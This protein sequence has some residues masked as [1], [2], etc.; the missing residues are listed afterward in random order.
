MTIDGCALGNPCH[1]FFHFAAR[2][3]QGRE[4][5]TDPFALTMIALEPGANR[6]V[7]AFTR[8]AAPD[9]SLTGQLR[10]PPCR[11]RA[12]SFFPEYPRWLLAQPAIVSG[13]GGEK[14]SSK[15]GNLDPRR[16]Q[17]S[18]ALTFNPQNFQVDSR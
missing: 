2:A 7:W 13:A 18:Y 5:V 4:P 8:N 6:R 12:S 14:S 10:I 16:K 15:E 3:E 9:C 1:L 17:F 11:P